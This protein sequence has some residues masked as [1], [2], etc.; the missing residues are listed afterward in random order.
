MYL[1]GIDPTS[2]PPPHQGKKD[3]V[4]LVYLVLIQWKL[5]LGSLGIPNHE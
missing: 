5:R 2:I 3:V 4:K 1:D